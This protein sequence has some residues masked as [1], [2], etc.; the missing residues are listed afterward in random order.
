MERKLITKKDALI[1]VLLLAAAA[2]VYAVPRLMAERGTRAVITCG[3]KAAGTLPLDKNGEYAYPELPDMVFTVSDGKISVTESG[4]GDK[5][6]IRTGGISRQGEA[7][8][9]VPNKAAVT[10]EGTPDN[11]NLDVVLK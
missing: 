1:I 8:I 11:N 2:A 3:D 7:I 6:C 4:C 10:I 9:C 5:T